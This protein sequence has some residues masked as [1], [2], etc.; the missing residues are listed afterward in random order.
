MPDACH[1]YI[2]LLKKSL[3]GGIHDPGCRAPVITVERCE[4]MMRDTGKA[5]APYLAAMG[6][7]LES[8]LASHGGP[9][10]PALLCWILHGMHRDTTPDTMSPLPFLDNLQFCLEEVIREKVP[11]DVIET[12]VWKGGLPLFMRGVLKA[13][14][15]ENRTVWVADSFAGLPKP[16]P[17]EHLQDALWHSLLEPLEGLKI[18]L[19]YVQAT[20]HK[21]GLLD[22]QVRFLEGWFSDTLPHAPIGQLALM[23]L[24]GDW[25]DSTMCVLETLYPKLSRG[26]Y[27]IIDDYGLPV[28]CRRAVDEYRHIHGIREPIRWVN[29]YGPQVAYWKKT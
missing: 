6:Q 16:D 1:L 27:I 21:Y 9:L 25:Y 24:D 14:G 11:G 23:R 5:F 7:S 19:D 18:P 8:L 3:T 28:G 22:R 2:D 26:G 17:Q 20:F 10:T 15:I 13:H 4:A 12:G 29:E